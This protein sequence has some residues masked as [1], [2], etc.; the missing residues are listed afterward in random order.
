MLG[1]HIDG[2]ADGWLGRCFDSLIDRF[3]NV[4]GNGEGGGWIDLILSGVKGYVEGGRWM[5]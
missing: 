2:A 4:W 5:D 3:N 1:G